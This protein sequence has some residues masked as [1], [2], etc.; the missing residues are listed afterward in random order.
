M[1]LYA[2]DVRQHTQVVSGQ[3]TIDYRLFDQRKRSRSSRLWSVRVITATRS[4][5]ADV[6]RPGTNA[7]D[8]PDG[9]L[10]QNED[11]RNPSAHFIQSDLLTTSFLRHH[12]CGCVPRQV[13]GSPPSTDTNDCVSDRYI[14][15]DDVSH[16]GLL[17]VE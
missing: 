15:V 11:V 9:A 1:N 7:A 10:W 3:T 2:G 13:V 14:A 16:V 12:S 6:A 4:R 5:T 8:A 17:S